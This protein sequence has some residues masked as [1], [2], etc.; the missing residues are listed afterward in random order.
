MAH[1]KRAYK[2]GLF[3]KR[4]EAVA[5]RFWDKVDKRGPDDCWPWLANKLPA[6]YGMFG[7]GGRHAGLILAHRWLWEHLHGPIPPKYTVDHLCNNTSCV[8]PKHLKAGPHRD[9]VARGRGNAFQINGAKTHCKH[10]HP[11]DDANTLIRY[12][13]DGTVKQRQCRMCDRLKHRH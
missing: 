7:R 12:R 2:K 8:N 10:G 5:D 1:Y 6:G 11:F 13:P 4:F 9:N 3:P